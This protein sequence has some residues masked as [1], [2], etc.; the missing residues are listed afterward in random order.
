M[1][2]RRVL[3]LVLL[4]IVI[5]FAPL[6]GRADEWPQY[7]GANRDGQAGVEGL[8]HSWIEAQPGEAWRRPIG[9]GFSAISIADGKVYTMEA[10]ETE[11][12]VLAIDASTGETIWR[13]VVGE[14]E[15][16]FPGG[17]PRTT[18]TVTDGMIYTVSSHSR[19]L[20]MR[21]D[22]GEILW[23]RNLQDY[24][25]VPRYGYSASPLVDGTRVLVL[26]GDRQKQPG[27]AAF[28]R[29]TGE[30][31][32]EALDGPAGYASPIVA[33]IDGVRQYIFSTFVSI[34]GLS[35]DG[36]VL[37]THETGPKTALPMPVFVAPDAV[38]VST[39]DDQFGGLMIRVTRGEAGFQ[40]EEV[41]KERLMRNHFNTSVLID[42][43]LYGFDNST[44][45]CLDAATGK[46]LWAK[47]GFGKGSLVAAGNLL[48]V[49]SDDGVAALV[50][51]SPE[52]YVEAGR[53]QVMEGRS[54]TAPSLADG[55]IFMRDF[56]EMVALDV[57]GSG[58]EMA[59]SAAPESTIAKMEFGPDGLS[60]EQ[61]IDKHVAAR[62]GRDNW[63]SVDGIA[64]DGIY[65][66]FSEQSNFTLVRQRGDSYRLDFEM[67][68]GHAIRA[69]DTEGH[70]WWQ[71]A[72]LQA[73]PARVVEGVYKPLLERESL[74]GP[75]LLDHAA[76]G[77]EVKLAGTGEIDGQ[78]TIE[79]LVT[80]PDG[81]EETWHL[82][83]QTYLE[84]AVDSSVH[85][86]TQAEGPID[87]RA[88]FSDFREVDGIVIPFR[89]D[90]EFGARLE[91]MRV[92][93]AKINPK[94][95]PTM[96]KAPPPP[97]PST[98][99][100]GEDGSDG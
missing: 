68:G 88:F 28:D 100:E 41:W 9:M 69:R 3:L 67:L 65:A 6:L 64:L 80:F 4:T 61:I 58:G 20:A 46:K 39:A 44:F 7:R 14:T 66:A 63:A 55:H 53:M 57:R 1:P 77:I 73:E 30:L 10:N 95:D 31:L 35:T 8:L 85:D 21:A 38:F 62:G 59:A 70:S 18:P 5:A 83:A 23:E 22:D 2:K 16:F 81:Q 76:R 49:L 72:L 96:L 74:F 17:G 98:D 24:G 84:L 97:P 48:Y 82:N 92:A 99:E 11:E 75:L 19:F 51:A 71:H 86:Y 45:R 29:A 78:A 91:E 60:V 93:N 40:T 52:G 87:Q 50:H 12:A 25:P 42:G 94:I 43:Y 54:W 89:I 56:D 47:R 79:L 26:V 33:E 32:W 27:V 34:T 36:E 90:L 37:W 13:K 15:E